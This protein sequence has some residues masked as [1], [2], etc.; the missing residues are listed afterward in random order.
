[1]SY[2]KRIILHSVILLAFL[3]T[4][5]PAQLPI[6]RR[7]QQNLNNDTSPSSLNESDRL[8]TILLDQAKGFESK[9]NLRGAHSSYKKILQKY[10]LSKIAP[11]AQL[12]KADLYIKS[13]KIEQGFDAYQQLVENYKQSNEFKKA[14]TQQ[15]EI[16]ENARE[17]KKSNFLGIP[18]KVHRAKQLEMYTKILENAPFTDFAPKAQFAMAEILKEDDRP[19]EA[20]KAYEKVIENYPRTAEGKE[21]QFQIGE[22]SRLTAT[23][24]QDSQVIREARDAMQTFVLTNPSNEKVNQARKAITELEQKQA[25]K[26][27]DIGRFYE[28][29]GKLRAASIYYSEVLKFPQAAEYADAESRLTSLRETNKEDIALGTVPKPKKKGRPTTAKRS[30]YVGPSKAQ[31]DKLLASPEPRISTRDITPLPVEEPALPAQSNDELE[32]NILPSLEN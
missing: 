28:K 21:A 13:G 2:S 18:T 25:T 12:S 15:F 26:S 30:D 22:L 32:E 4:E 10:P 8:A 5:L 17:G 11:T 3:S 7:N 29:T 1:M 6:F 14:I 31:L 9:G 23:N 24:T 16:A 27:Y 19:R 20:I